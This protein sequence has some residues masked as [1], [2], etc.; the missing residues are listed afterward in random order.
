MIRNK[1]AHGRNCF[2]EEYERISFELLLDI[3]YVIHLFEKHSD[4]NEAVEYIKNIVRWLEFPFSGQCTKKQI[5]E[6]LLNSVVL[7]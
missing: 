3:Q 7:Y 5:Y 1:V 2:K 4:T 6:K